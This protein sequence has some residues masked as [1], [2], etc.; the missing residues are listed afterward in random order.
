MR[1]AAPATAEHAFHGAL[2]H[3][4]NAV[5]GIL[6]ALG[7]ATAAR[8]IDA[9]ARDDGALAAG[10][11]EVADGVR[12]TLAWAHL[13][14]AQTFKERIELV[15]SDGIRRLEFPA[16][17]LLHAPTAY[18]SIRGRETITFG[19]WDEA[20]ER[21]LEHFHAAITAGV[22][23]RTPPEMAQLDHR[24]LSSLHDAAM[25]ATAA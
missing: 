22:P 21:Q 6:D 15:T 23:C 4:V 5:H 18:T 17:Y 16:P 1:S 14:A 10:L 11:V 13:P 19:A 25:A 12:W 3:D 9:H 7:V 8:V 20:Y 2:V 24:L